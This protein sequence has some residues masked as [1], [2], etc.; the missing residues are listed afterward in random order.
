MR[1]HAIT[2]T[3]QASAVVIDKQVK[4]A[5]GRIVHWVGD[6]N[7]HKIDWDFIKEIGAA[8]AFPFRFPPAM[9]EKSA[10][11]LNHIAAV[12]VSVR[13][14]TKMV[15]TY[16]DL[17]AL[18]EP[19]GTVTRKRLLLD[20]RRSRYDG[21]TTDANRIIE[22]STSEGIHLSP[23]QMEIYHRKRF[24]E[25][26]TLGGYEVSDGASS[27]REGNE[28][29]G[30]GGSRKGYHHVGDEPQTHHSTG[31]NES[32]DY[33]D[34]QCYPDGHPL[35][36]SL[37]GIAEKQQQQEVEYTLAGFRADHL[38]S[39]EAGT[40]IGSARHG[41]G[42]G[43]GV[44]VGSHTAL[45]AQGYASPRPSQHRMNLTDVIEVRVPDVLSK[46]HLLTKTPHTEEDEIDRLFTMPYGVALPKLL[47][48]SITEGS[49][50]VFDSTTD[51]QHRALVDFVPSKPILSADALAKS[52]VVSRIQSAVYD[53]S[54]S[55]HGTYKPPKLSNNARD[56]FSGSINFGMADSDDSMFDPSVNATQDAV[57]ALSFKRADLT[58]PQLE[59]IIERYMNPWQLDKLRKVDFRECKISP[60]G[61]R[62]LCVRFATM[63]NLIHVNLG[64]MNL[65]DMGCKHILESLLAGGVAG[66]LLR[67]ELDRNNITIATQ[68][69]LVINKFT[70]LR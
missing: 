26:Q 2:G 57:Q 69:L 9:L 41:M 68:N 31:D 61:V 4:L 1:R 14:N 48:N 19:Y 62:L 32:A 13:E 56:G 5:I 42:A 51:H 35:T 25:A 8:R 59:I 44:G 66:T 12:L 52:R 24:L 15:E 21:I 10:A 27:I 22:A 38:T 54:L 70:K 36:L 58:V 3:V 7:L 43:V 47:E 49:L 34:E 53:A 67:L 46:V 33:F 29:G 40:P 30:R 11:E 63:C 39:P 50:S 28:A 37:D 55:A 64:A 18:N 6:A 20:S 17:L 65:G 60:T 23:E 16:E 45:A